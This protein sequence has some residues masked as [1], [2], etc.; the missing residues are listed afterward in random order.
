[1]NSGGQSRALTLSAQL[2]LILG[3]LQK[4]ALGVVEWKLKQLVI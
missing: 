4:S 1:M 3:S 2:K